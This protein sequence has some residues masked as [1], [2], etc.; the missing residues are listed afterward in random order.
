M[1]KSILFLASFVFACMAM[2]CEA[3][4][5]PM[6]TLSRDLS[7]M[8]G[9]MSTADL[10]DNIATLA[11]DPQKTADVLNELATRNQDEIRNLSKEEKEKLLEA[12]VSAILP[13]SQLSETV[14]TLTSG[15]GKDFNKIV[16]ALCGGTPSVN[17]KALETALS[18]PEVLSSTDASTLALSAASLIVATVK[19][20]SA[21]GSVDT[22][23]EEFKQAVKDAGGV[24]TSFKSDEFKKKLQEKGFSEASASSLAA[25]M[26][27]AQ[28]L[29]GTAG[30]GQPNRKD[31][32]ANIKL[33][34]TSMGELLDEMTG[35]K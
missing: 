19:S 26:G 2:S 25:A 3:F 4:S 20:E 24:E 28:V 10:A 34:G 30:D 23:M 15:G 35:K 12:G 31:D 14:G 1:S 27:A 18:D 13:T 17:T 22:K 7:G 33:G 32:V 8:I 21:G 11:A 29:T 6:Y 16:E 5:K 9:S